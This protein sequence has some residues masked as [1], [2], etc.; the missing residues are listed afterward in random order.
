MT[1]AAN[2]APT[3]QRVSLQSLTRNAM[4][5]NGA[6]TECDLNYNPCIREDGEALIRNAIKERL[7]LS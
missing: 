7:D 1:T 6:L 4:F 3:L 5:L 2:M